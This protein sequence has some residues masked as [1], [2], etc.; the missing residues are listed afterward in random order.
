MN[1]LV[2]AALIG[3]ISGS[4]AA[5]PFTEQ[6]KRRLLLPYIRTATDC[7]ARSVIDNPAAVVA[8]QE[9]RGSD[10]VSAARNNCL[11]AIAKMVEVHDNLYGQNTGIGFFKGPYVDD[12]PRAVIARIQPELTRR[13][14]ETERAEIARRAELARKEEQNAQIDEERRKLIQEANEEHLACIKRAMIDLVP[15]TNESAEAV[16]IAIM[17]KCSGHD[18]KRARL[19]ASLFGV[20]ANQAKP[21]V[22]ELTEKMRKATISEI[23]TFRAER[24]KALIGAQEQKSP[25][26][27]TTPAVKSY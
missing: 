11:D 27:I 26:S 4:A 7:V 15:F 10:L 1:R 12:L 25:P 19:A 5:Q 8:A 9:S 24:A 23:V 3:A 18:S 21:I 16:S 13:A 22:A 17:A 6:Q 2:I 14:V 20:P